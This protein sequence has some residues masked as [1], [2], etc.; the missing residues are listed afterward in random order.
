MVK[1]YSSTPASA[2]ASDE[3]DSQ[4]TP[5][6]EITSDQFS[7]PAPDGELELSVGHQID[8]FSIV[9]VL[10]GGGMGRVVVARDT[11]LGRLVA[12]KFVRTDKMSEAR[13]KLLLT[14]AQIIAKCDHENIVRI[15][16]VGTHRGRLFLALQY[17]DG[18]PLRARLRDGPMESRE[19]MRTGLPVARALQGAHSR[20]IVH[21]DLKPDN[22]V[23]GRDGR[24][25][26]VDFG[27]SK[28]RSLHTD[29]ASHSP[30]GTPQY[31]APEQWHEEETL[32]S[33][34]DI[35]ALGVTLFELAAG[36]RPFAGPD[37]EAQV[38]HSDR[39]A[40]RLGSN[41]EALNAL[42]A[43]CLR[44][45]P[46]QR[47]SADQVAEALERGLA[48][49][50]PH[51]A[52]TPFRGL[53]SFDE[54]H[55][56][57]FRGR[58]LEIDA[59]VER[60]RHQPFIGI[61]GASGAGKSSLVFAG[62]VPRL[63][64]Q[65]PWAV[66]RMQPGIHPW[67]TLAARI[68]RARNHNPGTETEVDEID[69]LA[70]RLATGPGHLNLELRDLARE[71]RA[72]V[73]LVVDQFEEMYTL[74][75]DH[76]TR[77]QFAEA[78][79]GSADLAND[80]VRVVC[81]LRE[82]FLAATADVPALRGALERPFLLGAPGPDQLRDIVTRPMH[83]FELRFDDDSLVDDM[84]GVVSGEPGCLALLQFTCQQLWERRDVAHGVL[85][86]ADYETI[87]GVEGSLAAYAEQFVSRL[88]VADRHIAREVLQRLITPDRTRRSVEIDALASG[89]LNGA[90]IVRRLVDSR[91]L[92]QRPAP[93]GD[94]TIVE[95]VHESLIRHW[96]RL[97]AWLRENVDEQHLRRD[98]ELAVSHWQSTQSMA[99]A[100]A[101]ALLE[102]IDRV[103]I[104]LT[105]AEGEFVAETRKRERKR[106]SRRQLLA[107]GAMVL[108]AGGVALANYIERERVEAIA[109]ATMVGFDERQKAD[110]DL[111]VFEL[112][113]VG[114]DWRAGATVPEPDERPGVFTDWTLLRGGER[115]RVEHVE[116]Q[117]GGNWRVE[118]RGGPA[119]LRVRR[120]GCMPSELRIEALPGYS[121]RQEP[122]RRLSI[123]VP[124]CEASATGTV[125][126]PAGSFIRGGDG[127]PTTQAKHH[128]PERTIYL[129]AI[130]V[131]TTEV[132]NAAFRV[133]ADMSSFTGD[134]PPEYPMKPA[135][136]R[137]ISGALHPVTGI[138]QRSAEAY[139]RFMGKRLPTSA[140]WE[141]AARGGLMIPTGGATVANAAPRRS[142][143]WGGPLIA[144]N[145]NLRGADDGHATSAPVGAYPRD[146]SP[147]GIFDLAG[148]VFEWTAT[149]APGARTLVIVRGGAWTSAPDKQQ[150]ATMY[151]NSK[152]PRYF[153]FD[154]GFRCVFEAD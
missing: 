12:L 120:P 13:A 83:R 1:V 151:E 71:L 16:D 137:D 108:A 152:S 75:G 110:R 6:A 53:E 84:L 130:A 132:T 116:E 62:L 36:R 41:N 135:A 73:V 138:D 60:L 127:R 107:A 101:M 51:D 134:P 93:T 106:T 140:E 105:T 92:H 39:D 141:K 112:E 43:K 21:C 45:A 81:T 63:R 146:M 149:A 89:L 70:S 128:S 85:R 95:L 22:V 66:L 94:H 48:D 154:H 5:D 143:P 34:A 19:V 47:P 31:M 126:I 38:A 91:L 147:Y 139:C 104:A 42:V 30:V 55:A 77:R 90:D 33:A 52:S 136:L 119:I 114:Y 26:V 117:P 67:R 113:I 10:R 133:Y 124:T 17:I 122:M 24:V 7:E 37:F 109:R 2:S 111:G 25:Y 99:I 59:L 102:R 64:E 78:L 54:A 11:T 98:L 32:T 14:E 118:A 23:V 58:D 88:T 18:E 131:D 40:P 79:V 100:P 27:V 129:P 150:Y 74:G 15:Y 125:E 49:V 4:T 9:R 35:W 86:R 44:R 148:N 69:A 46:S 72:R 142:A 145:A 82:D 3:P 28:L 50:V 57:L 68:L 61:V 20:Q 123:R 121:A 76:V 56:A 8:R 97:D 153:A 115:V 144:G 80:P 29:T 87:G 103:G 96:Q 65:G